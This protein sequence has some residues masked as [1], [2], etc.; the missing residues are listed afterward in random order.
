MDWVHD[1]LVNAAF[2]SIH[3][4]G[5]FNAE[6]LAKLA[7]GQFIDRNGKR[8]ATCRDCRKVIRIDKPMLGSLHLCN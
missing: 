8:Y 6:E 3:H 2:S 4:D 5:T 7:N 1:R